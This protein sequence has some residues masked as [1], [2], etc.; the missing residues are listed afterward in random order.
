[1][2]EHKVK[3]DHTQSLPLLTSSVELEQQEPSALRAA[4]RTLTRMDLGAA[5]EE[6]ERQREEQLDDLREQRQIKHKCNAIREQMSTPRI[7]RR[8]P[9][10]S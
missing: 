5:D 6:R 9:F 2:A 3:D 10:S 4:I 1:M 7:F 8:K